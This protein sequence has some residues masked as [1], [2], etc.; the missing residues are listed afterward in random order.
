MVVIARKIGRQFFDAGGD[1]QEP[2]SEPTS[3]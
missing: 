2:V 1:F 3:L